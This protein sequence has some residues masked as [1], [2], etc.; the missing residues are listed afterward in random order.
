MAVDHLG[1]DRLRLGTFLHLHLR[2]CCWDLRSDLFFSE[3]L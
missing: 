2:F 1:T 3:D